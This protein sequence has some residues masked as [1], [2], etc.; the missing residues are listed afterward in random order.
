MKKFLRRVRSQLPLILLMLLTQ[1]VLAQKSVNGRVIDKGSKAAIPNAS[2]ALK[3]TSTGT[4]TNA[5][6]TFTIKTNKADDVL[7]ITS[8]GY[9]A[10]DVSLKASDSLIIE[11]APSNSTLN[12][13][14]VT[15]YTA[16]RK[17]DITG[18]VAVVN[19]KELVANPGSNVETLLT[20]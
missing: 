1:T 17:K 5:N 4:Q 7:T 12:E 6:G 18:S 9:D 11:L 19:T 13:I 10:I 15:G 16:Q 3:G 20:G 14:L 8:V 2:V